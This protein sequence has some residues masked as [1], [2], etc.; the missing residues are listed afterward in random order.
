MNNMVNIRNVKMIEVS[1]WDDLVTAFSEN[2]INGFL[3]TLNKRGIVTVVMVISNIKAPF[4]SILFL[5][6]AGS[7]CSVFIQI[8]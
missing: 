6:L 8:G 4:R 7:I 2:L 1:D 5:F 3:I